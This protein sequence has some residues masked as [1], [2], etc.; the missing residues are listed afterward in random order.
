MND[1][2]EQFGRGAL[3]A[4]EG[5][6]QNF[7]GAADC[8]LKAADQGHALA[9]FNLGIMYGKGQ[10]VSRN[11]ALSVMWMTRAA[12]L[13]DAGAQYNL[14]MKRHRTSLGELPEIAFESRIEAYKWLRLAAAQGYGASEAGSEV[15]AMGMTIDSVT[16]GK[17]RAAA[18][19]AGQVPA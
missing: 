17:R 8:Y 1:A 11:E 13:G 7:E 5:T 18:F 9:Q 4:S 10:G 12:K 19:V 6:R 15:V 2:E 14:G 16:E 3:L